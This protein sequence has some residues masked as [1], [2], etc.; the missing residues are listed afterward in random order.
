MRVPNDELLAHEVGDE[1]DL[2][3]GGHDHHY[4]VKPVGP[5]NCYVL[6]SGT[7]FRDITVLELNYTDS[8]RG[9]D[10]KA[11]RHEEINGSI[12]EDPEMAAL[13]AECE[14]K[15]GSEMDKV[16]GE[17]AVDLDSRFT[18]IR[19]KETNIGNFITDCMRDALSADVALLNS[20]TLRAD[21]IIPEGELQVRH[22]VNLLPMLDELC[23]MQM[24]G[25]QML[26]A[27]E[28]GVSQYPRLEGRF[29]QLSGIELTFD[30]NQ[31]AGSRIVDGSVRVGGKPLESEERYKLCTKDYL[32]QGKDGY[33]VFKEC[34]CLADG[35]QAGI[36][37]TVVR[38]HFR[39]IAVLNGYKVATE[40]QVRHGRRASARG[41]VVL[42]GEGPSMLQHYAISPEVE[43]R[44]KCLNPVA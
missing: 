17:T 27:L 16:I 10:I 2:I 41:S 15:V 18:S 34:V 8:G 37:P 32:R 5:H 1:I 23:L 35:E 21:A 39:Q 20:G 7:D 44:I 14:A 29:P 22:L 31:P 28:N 24:T 12:T 38:D 26:Q 30:A 3:L 25:E 43:G 19:T 40:A 13:V 42:T 36:I 11:H 9:F 33:D 4:D 6:K